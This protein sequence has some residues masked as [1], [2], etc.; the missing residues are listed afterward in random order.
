MPQTLEASTLMTSLM[1][2]ATAVHP[3]GHMI[4]HDNAMLHAASLTQSIT[5]HIAQLGCEAFQYT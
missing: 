4:S 3:A 5:H 1:T 2:T